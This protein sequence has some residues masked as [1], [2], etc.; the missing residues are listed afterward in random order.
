MSTAMLSSSGDGDVAAKPVNTSDNTRRR[1]GGASIS[2]PPTKRSKG[3]FTDTG[4]ICV[5]LT[6]CVCVCVCVCVLSDQLLLLKK[7]KGRSW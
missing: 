5:L 3:I 2:A 7:R 1:V 6:L 4:V